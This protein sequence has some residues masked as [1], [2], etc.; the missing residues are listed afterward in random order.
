MDTETP[1]YLMNSAEEKLVVSILLIG[2]TYPVSSAAPVEFQLV[3]N[4]KSNTMLR[5]QKV[6]ARKERFIQLAIPLLSV[7]NARERH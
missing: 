3:V 7:A 2:S 1:P 6:G 4:K 5:H